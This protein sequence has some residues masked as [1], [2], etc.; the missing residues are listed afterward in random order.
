MIS[1]ALA[2]LLL[3]SATCMGQPKSTT[4]LDQVECDP[5][6]PHFS[7]GDVNLTKENYEEYKRAH[8]VFLLGLSDSEC[9]KCCYMEKMLEKLKSLLST[10]FTYRG[11]AI[12]VA[13][14]NIKAARGSFAT[15]LPALHYFPKILLY[16][17]LSLRSSV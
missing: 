4:D 10:R 8:S 9:E 17:Y 5:R 1:P 7:V 13:R 15:D 11:Q 2:L 14:I 16:K 3:F 12:P 6:L